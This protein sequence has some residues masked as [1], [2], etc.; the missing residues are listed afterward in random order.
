MITKE[1]FYEIW[2]EVDTALKNTF[3]EL[4]IK[5]Y[6]EF[7]LLLA[8]AE[9]DK[10]YE[11]N[12]YISAYSVDY[13]YNKD[14]Y[15]DENGIYII[16]NNLDSYYRYDGRDYQQILNFM[17]GT[18]IWDTMPFLK[19]LYRL[20]YLV[21]EGK[22]HWEVEF[23]DIEKYQIIQKVIKGNFKSKNNP[24]S[25]IIEKGYYS[26]SVIKKALKHSDDSFFKI[27]TSIKLDDYK[28]DET[29]EVKEISF[30]EWS[31]RFVYST[32][33]YYYFDKLTREYR[34]KIYPEQIFKLE[35]ASKTGN[36][37]CFRYNKDTD[38]FGSVKL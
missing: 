26:L 3:N 21:K 8:Y 37:L 13:Y 27:N 6:N 23:P 35:K 38:E 17:I 28:G 2:N 15:K 31:E 10:K 7:V 24:L 19:R 25:D 29:W 36:D 14:I 30:N 16:Y 34:K 32:L 11:T 22:Y 4:E 9:Y 5:C 20:S 33:L 1:R 12:R 18:S